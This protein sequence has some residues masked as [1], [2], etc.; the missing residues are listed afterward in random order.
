MWLGVMVLLY[1]KADEVTKDPCRICSEQ[2]GE[3]VT[4][5]AGE[6]IQK[7]RTYYPNGSEVDSADQ[8]FVRNQQTRVEVDDL[9]RLLNATSEPGVS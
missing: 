3:A 4:C 5:V 7:Y 9:R 1:V 6:L 2:H 8:V